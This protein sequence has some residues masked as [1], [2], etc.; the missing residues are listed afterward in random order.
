MELTPLP[1]PGCY[2][3]DFAPQA[4]ARGTFVKTVHAPTFATQPGLSWSFRESYFST[5]AAGVLR[6][7]HLQLPPYDHGKLVYCTAGRVLDVVVD[8][9][10]GPTFGQ[11]YSL[12]L[13]PATPQG[14]YIAHGCAHG[15]LAFEPSTLVYHTTLEYAPSHDGGIR[16]DSFGF[17]WPLPNPT[18]SDRD[19]A[20]PGLEAFAKPR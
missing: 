12:E 3:L 13:S 5:S 7:M 10:H 18:V 14:L 6:G 4:D 1:L 11:Y 8:L 17:A 20:L 16:Y 15:F 9:R 19:R 2:R